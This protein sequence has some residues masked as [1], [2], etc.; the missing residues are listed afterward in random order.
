LIPVLAVWNHL[1]S[2]WARLRRRP[3]HARDE[4]RSSAA[5]E[6]FWTEVRAGER[7]AEASV[8]P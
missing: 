5:R 2:A 6:R 8:R 3:R 7:E 4:R 1:R